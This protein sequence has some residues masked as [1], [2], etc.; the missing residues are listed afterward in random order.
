VLIAA[1]HVDERRDVWRAFTAGDP[2]ASRQIAAEADYLIVPGSV[3][4]AYWRMVRP[5]TWNVFESA[6]RKPRG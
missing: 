3:N 1:S 5:G 4:S 2:A 6:I